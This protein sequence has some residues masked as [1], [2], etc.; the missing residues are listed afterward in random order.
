MGGPCSL[1]T[2]DGTSSPTYLLEYNIDDDSFMCTDSSGGPNFIAT[3][4]L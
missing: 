1:S 4:K 3:K 2:S